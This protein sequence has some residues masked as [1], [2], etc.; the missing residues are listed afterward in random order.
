MTWYWFLRGRLTEARRAL[1]AAFAIE[2]DAPGPARAFA[3]AW[4]A[5]ITLLAGGGGDPAEDAR[6]ALKLYHDIDDPGGRAA[7]EWFLGFA[8]SDFGHLAPSEDLV[9]RAL[10][11]FRASATDGES[12]RR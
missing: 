3:M 9:S 7:A 1:E 6:T 10:A 11:A 5:G 2:G 12:L 8:T 4:Q